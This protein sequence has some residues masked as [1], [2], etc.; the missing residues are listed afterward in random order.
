MSRSSC[1]IGSL[2]QASLLALNF[3]RVG[4][5]LSKDVTAS[6]EC[7]GCTGSAAL[8]RKTLTSGLIAFLQSASLGFVRT[9]L[10]RFNG[11]RLLGGVA[12]IGARSI[13]T[14]ARSIIAR[15]RSIV[16]R[17]IVHDLDHVAVAAT[18]S[19]LAQAL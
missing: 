2:S 17:S 3:L 7:R 19:A 11:A 13:I 6:S 16:A 10:L 9:R 1:S 4:A 14:R 8:Q 12:T 15:A 5:E 18:A